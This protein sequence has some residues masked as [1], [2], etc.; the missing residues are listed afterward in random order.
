MILS[1]HHNIVKC[2]VMEPHGL[3]PKGFWSHFF[4]RFIKAQE[5]G[6]I[7]R[8]NTWEMF[9]ACIREQV[10]PITHPLS[11]HSRTNPLLRLFVHVNFDP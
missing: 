2:R 4:H 6:A 11:N 3:A 5:E 10:E 9:N 1:F 7:V 8:G